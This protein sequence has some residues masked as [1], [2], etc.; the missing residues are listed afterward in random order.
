MSELLQLLFFF[1]L[2][3]CIG[4]VSWL[5][6]LEKRAG[7]GWVR[8]VL[9]VLIGAFTLFFGGFAALL[10][11]ALSQPDFGQELVSQS[12][13]ELSFFVPIFY[14]VA[15][16]GVVTLA[17][18]FF[19]WLL[20]RAGVTLPLPDRHQP[21]FCWLVGS[22]T[23]DSVVHLWSLYIFLAS[24]IFFGIIL[25]L[26]DPLVL[27][28]E[29]K[30]SNLYLSSLLNMVIF[31][32][33]AIQASGFWLNYSPRQVWHEMGLG[34][35]NKRLLAIG[36]GSAVVLTILVTVLN[37][38]VEPYVDPNILKAVEAISQSLAPPDKPWLV[39]LSGLVIGLCAGIGEEM[40]FRGLIQPVF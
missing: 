37:S 22:F 34:A 20:A 14:L 38:L 6:Y 9:L 32:T 36:L 10:H 40:L 4:T 7:L 13:V 33:F 24:A 11:W 23:L 3:L 26:A 39:L 17:L 30:H 12:P 18:P 2:L 21:P 25:V 16:A 29:M 19:R 31:T 27:A 28:A 35:L 1:V 15:A 5:G 8:Y